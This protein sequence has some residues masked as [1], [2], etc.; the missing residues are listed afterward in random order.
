MSSLL[1]LPASRVPFLA[2]CLLLGL[3]NS[4]QAADPAN[5]G[6]R[7][8]NVERYGICVRVPQAWSLTNW[9]R[10]ARAFE[11]T[12][13]QEPS[14]ALG[15]VTCDLGIAPDSLEDYRK[16]LEETDK[17]E[18]APPDRHPSDPEKKLIYERKKPTRK[19]TG[20][21]VEPI[22]PKK[23]GKERA[24]ALKERLVTTWEY[25]TADGETWFEIR[26]ALVSH[27]HLYTFSLATDE[28]HYDSYRLD[29]DDMLAAAQFTAPET[30]LQRLPGGYW[31]Q[32]DFKFALWLPASWKPSFGP[33]DKVLFFATGEAHEAFTDSVLVLAGPPEKL[34]LKELKERLPGEIAKADAAATVVSCEVVPLGDVA[35]LEL[36]VKTKKGPLEITIVERRFSSDRCRYEVRYTVLSSQYEKLKEEIKKSHDSFRE[37]LNK[38]EREAL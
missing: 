32:R 23:Y 15:T 1:R 7:A 10:N 24:E 25:E 26:V 30:G 14:S 28:G 29:F 3:A 9:A 21:K 36:V 27:G 16:R 6:L 11:L 38:T 35:A 13:P 18:K 34:A 5:D 4:S 8:V 19:L 37:V 17:A 2:T 31:M 22:D 33:N 12:A 20:N